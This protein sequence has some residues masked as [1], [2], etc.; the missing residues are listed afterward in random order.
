MRLGGGSGYA[1]DPVCGMQVE[2]ANAPATLF[3]G[4]ATHYFC[5]DH[6]RHRLEADPGRFLTG[7]GERPVHPNQPSVPSADR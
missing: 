5:S 3:D 7:T 2:S 4:S 1:I 6:C